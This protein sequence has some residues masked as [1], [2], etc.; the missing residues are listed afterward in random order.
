MG[1]IFNSKLENIDFDTG[2]DFA[3]LFEKFNEN[4]EKKEGAI[5]KGKITDIK[6]D[7]VIVDIG[8]KDE[9]RV[10]I[11]EFVHNGK[12]PELSIGEEIDVYIET[13][14]NRRGQVILSREHAVRD[15]SWGN[16]EKAMKKGEPVEG[17]VFGR[18]KG[19][20]T[21]DLSGVIAF[22]PGSQI[23]V[24]PIKDITNLLGVVQPFMVLKID[25]EQGNV[26]VSR[27]AIIEESRAEAR[28]EMLSKIEVGQVLEGTVK[29]ITDYGAFVDLNN[30]D[31]LLHVTDISWTK[32]NHPSEVLS[33]G[34]KVTVQIIKYDADTKRLSL[35]MKQLE[36]NPW[37]GLDAKYPV[38]K[39]MVG[40]ITNI[41]DYGVFVEIEPGI[42]GL[43]HV[44]ELSWNKHNVSPKKLVKE[45]QEVE[46]VI[47]DIDVDKHR[48]SLGMKQCMEN[49]WKKLSKTYSVGTVVEGE[50]E[51]ILD[52]G[53]FI[54]FG[55]EVRGLIHANDISWVESPEKTL[56]TYKKGDKVK[57]MVLAI[58]TE[59][60]R[61]NFGVKQLDKD[62]FE[63]VFENLKKGSV[64]TCIVKAIE[65]DGINIEVGKGIYSFIKKSDLSNDKLE[66]R[67]DR[68]AKGD[69]VDA[70]IV[71]LDKTHRKVTLSI[72]A[73]ENEEHKKKI[74]EYGS[75]SSGA[76]LGDILGEAISEV[77]GKKSSAAKEKKEKEEKKA[78]SS[79]GSKKKK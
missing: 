24:K 44:S 2:E 43:V 48:I 18:V 14:E 20:L 66:Q 65:S 49:I 16:L 19:G 71:Q 25:K 11:K 77:E 76:S 4:N 69:R 22:L 34:Q 12:L 26:V 45:G 13:Y 67:P 53:I 31:G 78:K 46:F 68:L 56:K 70:K 63:E 52:F 72:K 29:N 61:V 32:I 21:V 54:N 30:I 73:L 33:I 51:K 64:V 36:K 6:N 40:K 41:A 5:V 37:E 27:R 50:I 62:P 60:E 38:G 57:A 10:P 59:K 79:S 75:V 74:A 58:D 39:K 7:T 8:F 23:D 3:Q 17:V 47:L 15:N 35:G 9:G 1:K 28:D 55:E 42:E